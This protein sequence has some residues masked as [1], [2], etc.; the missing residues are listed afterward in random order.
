[1]NY[2]TTQLFEEGAVEEAKIEYFE[3]IINVIEESQLGKIIHENDVDRLGL[4]ELAVREYGRKSFDELLDDPVELADVIKRTNDGIKGSR[5]TLQTIT[6]VTLTKDDIAVTEI[7]NAVTGQRFTA[8]LFRGTGRA[9]PEEIYSDSTLTHSGAILGSRHNGS[10]VL[11]SSPNKKASEFYGKTTQLVRADFHN[12]LVID[13]DNA[14]LAVT[15]QAGLISYMP[16]SFAETMQLQKFITDAGH[17]GVIVRVPLDEMSGKKLQNAFG[18]DQV[19]DFTEKV[20][21]PVPFKVKG[22]KA[23]VPGG[24]ELPED[25]RLPG[26]AET[27]A[28]FRIKTI[29]GEDAYRG[30]HVE[31]MSFPEGPIPLRDN[32]IIEMA[33]AIVRKTTPLRSTPDGEVSWI[34]EANDEIMSEIDPMF[35]EEE[36]MLSF[37]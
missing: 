34:S 11:Y 13:S 6:D 22:S 20:V 33:Q 1:M 16:G 37:L 2:S 32:D 36:K 8:N 28:S 17:D 14:W 24:R 18:E 23:H 4:N 5:Q 31:G 3:E 26:Q 9:T 27:L 35:T 29:D 15:R 7:A 10:P 12:P 21:K 19:I 30:K 25:I